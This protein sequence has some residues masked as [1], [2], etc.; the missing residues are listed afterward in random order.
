M[1][2][3]IP[4]K[5]FSDNYVWLL[6]DAAKKKGVVFDPGS[7]KPVLSYLKK[8]GIELCGILITH[9]HMDHTGGINELLQ[10]F[11]V[12]VYGGAGDGIPGCTHPLGEGA[13][14]EIAE[15]GLALRVIDTPGHTRGHVV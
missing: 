3:I 4:I 8:S 10:R 2:H 9:H 13:V 12:P 6:T 7:A 1:N 11:D 5:A 15:C 14:I